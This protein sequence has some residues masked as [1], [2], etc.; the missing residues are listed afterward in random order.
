MAYSPDG[1]TLASGGVDGTIRLWP[2]LEGLRE[3]GCRQVRRNLTQEEWALY[4]GE[5]EPYRETCP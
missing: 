5:E 4:L 1:L 3:I 2:T